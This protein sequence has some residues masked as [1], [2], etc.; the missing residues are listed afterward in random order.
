MNVGNKLES[1][2]LTNT[3]ISEGGKPMAGTW[4]NFS[5]PSGVSADTTLLLTD[6]SVMVHNPDFPGSLGTGGTDWYR[7]TPDA[8]GAYDTGSWSGAL[9]MATGRQFFA[10]GVLK[11]GRVFV[12]GGEYSNLFAQDQNTLGEIFDPATNLW[13]PMT[14][15]TPQFDFIA[16]DCPSCVMA[17][18]RVLIGGA[19]T[20]RTA[21]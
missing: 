4:N 10:S 19:Q 21:I 11:D 13:T 16:G 15:P 3:V 14:K 6:G 7:L 20:V 18:G 9:N 1:L 2:V 8:N 5:A 17:D 12:V